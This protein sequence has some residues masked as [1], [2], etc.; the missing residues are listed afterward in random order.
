M[1]AYVLTPDGKVTQLLDNYM[2][3]A[4]Q[5]AACVRVEFT[6]TDACDHCGY[7]GLVDCWFDAE[8]LSGGFDCPVC[9]TYHERKV[10]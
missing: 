7:H 4:E 10:F 3:D 8:T 2:T 6:R 9:T 5:E 1:R